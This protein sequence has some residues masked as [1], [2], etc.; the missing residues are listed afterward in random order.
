MVSGELRRR[1]GMEEKRSLFG[2]RLDDK[3]IGVGG[4]CPKPL[5]KVPSEM[6][7]RDQIREYIVHDLAVE[8]SVRE[9][10]SSD[11]RVMQNVGGGRAPKPH[12]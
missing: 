5:H 11:E 7:I 2:V 10:Y 1:E 8:H 3:P 4:S 6:I 9:T 12:L